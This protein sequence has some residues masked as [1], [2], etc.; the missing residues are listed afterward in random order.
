MTAEA[1][2][3]EGATAHGIPQLVL[4]AVIAV[5]LLVDA[6]V[7][8]RLAPGYQ[9]SAPSGIGAGNL[10]RLEAAAALLVALWVLARGSRAALVAALAVGFSACAAVVLYRY[11]E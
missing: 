1:G 3:A 11:V 7:H 10:F 4:R 9:Q 8:L 2:R 5:T 6:V